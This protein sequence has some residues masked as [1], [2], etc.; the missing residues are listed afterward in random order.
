M[1]LLVMTSFLS[2]LPYTLAVPTIQPKSFG[3]DDCYWASKY[4]PWTYM[5]CYSDADT[6]LPNYVDYTVR[7]TGTGQLPSTW[8]SGFYSALSQQCGASYYSTTVCNMA[9]PYTSVD[10][11]DG[12]DDWVLTTVSGIEMSFRMDTTALNG[13]NGHACVATAVQMATCS[14]VQIANGANCY[15]DGY[16]D[17]SILEFDE[18]LTPIS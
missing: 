13:D 12:D 17:M 9:S 2:V 4:M 8:C 15:N 14:G 18:I 1:H 10:T 11:L 16:S 3:D 5:D 7:M 6:F